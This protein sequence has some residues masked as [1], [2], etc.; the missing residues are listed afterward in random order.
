MPEV[1]RRHMITHSREKVHNC[2]ECGESYGRAELLI[3][4]GTFSFT[5]G[6]DHIKTHSLKKPKQCKCCKYST[7]QLW[8]LIKHILTLSGV[9][10]YHCKECRSSFSQAQHL[11]SH[12]CIHSGEKSYKCPQCSYSSAPSS[13]LKK[14]HDQAFNKWLILPYHMVRTNIFTIECLSLF[15][16]N[17]AHTLFRNYKVLSQMT[18]RMFSCS[19]PLHCR[20]SN[21]FI[22]PRSDH[23][24]AR[25]SMICSM[26]LKAWLIGLWTGC[27]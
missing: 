24:L 26:L 6:R 4:K 17:G 25:V 8:S 13:E 9:K 15:M 10:P 5:I 12:L 20:F 1:L 3:W 16:N 2:W 19:M 11:K 27:W 7:V 18:G 22:K 14:T 23:C 21:I